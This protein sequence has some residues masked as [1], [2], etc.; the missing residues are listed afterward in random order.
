VWAED[1]PL[2]YSQLLSLLSE[3]AVDPQR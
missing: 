2:I 1:D 3:F